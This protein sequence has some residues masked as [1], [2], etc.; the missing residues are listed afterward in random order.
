MHG[1]YRRW[2]LI[3]TRF[4]RWLEQGLWDAMVQRLLD[5]ELTDD[6]KKIDTAN[7]YERPHC[8]SPA[9]LTSSPSAA[10]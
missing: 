5:P 6:W 7:L 1:R 9:S 8:P 4:W 3:Y 2:T 10:A